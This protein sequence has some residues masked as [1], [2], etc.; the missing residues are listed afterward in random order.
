MKLNEPSRWHSHS[1]G[2]S[3][4]VLRKDLNLQIEDFGEKPDLSSEL[5]SY[6]KLLTDYIGKLGQVDVLHM[7]GR[8]MPLFGGA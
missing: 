8:Y 3:M 7:P 6:F 1:R 2:I 5:R 4:D